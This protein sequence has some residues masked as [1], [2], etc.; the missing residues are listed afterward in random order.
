M[1]YSHNK[2]SQCKLLERKHAGLR[3][4]PACAM[5]LSRTASLPRC[6]RNAPRP[7]CGH[8]CMGHHCQRKQ[9]LAACAHAASSPRQAGGRHSH[10]GAR[11][12]LR[13][14]ALNH[15]A[16]WVSGLLVGVRHHD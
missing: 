16:Q 4:M 11:R 7:R 2:F 9:L 10:A 1:P 13:T 15:S 8:G 5:A 6:T 14:Q 12:Q 3:R